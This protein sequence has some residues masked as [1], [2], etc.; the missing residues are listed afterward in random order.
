MAAVG[1]A[2]LRVAG[3]G[4]ARGAAAEGAGAAAGAGRM[5]NFTKGM[6]AHKMIA[7]GG[8]KNEQQ[9]QT[10]SNYIATM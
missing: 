3:A 5:S 8:D 4:L 9:G 1:G 2:L 10:G 6:I 7:G